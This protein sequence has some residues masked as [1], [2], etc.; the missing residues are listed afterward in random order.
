MGN[1]S[2]GLFKAGLTEH[3]RNVIT[4]PATERLPLG[5]LFCGVQIKSGLNFSCLLKGSCEQLFHQLSDR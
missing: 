4:K 2:T 5:C 3:Y 1:E